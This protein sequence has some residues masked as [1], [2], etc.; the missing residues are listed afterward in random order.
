VNPGEIYFQKRLIPLPIFPHLP[1]MVQFAKTPP[2]S[3]V[4]D[5]GEGSKVSIASSSEQESANG[6]PKRKSDEREGQSK[7]KRKSK[8]EKGDK[9]NGRPSKKK[10]RHS[11]SKPARDPRDEASP[12]GTEED[13][14]GTRSPSPV[15]DFDGLSRP[16]MS[17][18]VSLARQC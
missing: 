2:K 3:K 1:K 17:L 8:S 4:E 10:R 13:V 12:P 7:K 9:V 5:E 14:A 15:I 18:E 6:S 11:V 16:S